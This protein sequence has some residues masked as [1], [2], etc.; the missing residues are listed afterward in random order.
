ML[1]ISSPQ[2]TEQKESEKTNMAAMCDPMSDTYSFPSRCP[3]GSIRYRVR[4][5]NAHY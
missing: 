2:Q 5:S 4:E 3:S 1:A